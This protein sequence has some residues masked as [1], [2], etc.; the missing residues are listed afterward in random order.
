MTGFDHPDWENL[1]RAVVAASADDVPRLVAADWLDEHGQPERAEF[2]RVQVELARLET[3]GNGATTAAEALRRKE[4]TFLGPLATHR[5][6]WA[7]EACPELVRVEFRDR[8]VA[9][10]ESMR[11]AGA[12]R[13]T[14][15]RGFVE[16]V[17]CPAADWLAHGGEVR[18]RQPVRDVRLTDC[19]RL[20][21]SQ[22][23][24]ILPTLDGLA[25][26]R[27]SFADAGRIDWL[28]EQLPDT[29]IQPRPVR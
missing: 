9:S 25:S 18:A 17:L 2:I 24:E 3:A 7:L 4:R 20:T 21:P 19:D 12:E 14:F 27:I 13:L 22:W 8:A 11:V 16:A 26:A 28:R 5:A 23:F 15:R 1:L 29:I 10:L 6:L